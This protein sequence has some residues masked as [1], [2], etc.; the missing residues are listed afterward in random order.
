MGHVRPARRFPLRCGKLARLKIFNASV[1]ILHSD[2]AVPAAL[3]E[4]SDEI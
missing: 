2:K 3:P 4:D 1:L